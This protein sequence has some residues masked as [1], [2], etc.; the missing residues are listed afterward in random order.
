MNIS[1]AVVITEPEHIQEVLQ[2]LE[3][4]GL[5]EVYFHD[6]KSGKIVIIIE[7]EDVNE[8]TFKLKQIQTLPHVLFANMV[9]SYS[10]EEWESAA[11]YLQKLSNDVPEMLNDENVKAEDIVYKGHIKGYIS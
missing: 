11:E 9:Y 10:E 1:S 2:S 5:C 3:E 8:E 4:S 7:G 6:D